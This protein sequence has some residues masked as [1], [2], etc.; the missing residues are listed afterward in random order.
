MSNNSDDAINAIP[1]PMTPKSSCVELST[2]GSAT[3]TEN[4]VSN[5]ETTSDSM[6]EDESK[7]LQKYKNLKKKSS[8]LRQSKPKRFDSAEYFINI[9]KLKRKN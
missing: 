2:E 6:T 8:L 1:E 7:F 5:N 9:E 4:S 3:N